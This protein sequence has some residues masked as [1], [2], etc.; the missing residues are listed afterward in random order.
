MMDGDHFVIEIGVGT[1][2]PSVRPFARDATYVGVDVDASLLT[3]HTSPVVAA[4]A[5]RLP[6]ADHSVDFVVACN[7]F[8]DVG[9][10]FGFEEAVGFDP[11]GYAEHVKQLVARGAVRELEVLRARVRAMTTMV[12][13][14][15][16][17]MLR[18]AARVLRRGG[19]VIV[20]ETLTPQFAHEWIGG[21]GGGRANESTLIPAGMEYR[22]RAVKTHNRRRR[23]CVSAELANPSLMVWVLTPGNQR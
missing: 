20:V 22:C 9:L 16:L 3:R 23:Y 13:A 6:F 12:A 5:T 1:D 15:K 17:D 18:E 19:E 11:P 4:D 21:L 14:T 10:G 2:V 8:G 7:V